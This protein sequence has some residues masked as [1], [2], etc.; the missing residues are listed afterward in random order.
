MRGWPFG[1]QSLSCN[2]YD[3]FIRTGFSF[4]LVMTRQYP[5]VPLLTGML[6]AQAQSFLPFQVQSKRFR[7]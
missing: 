6:E 1:Y 2:C 5:S 7:T 3:F 4:F